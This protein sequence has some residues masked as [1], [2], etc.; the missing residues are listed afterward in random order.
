MN[1]EEKK[2]WLKARKKYLYVEFDCHCV[3]T[4][5]DCIFK[6]RST[7]DCV[8][9]SGCD[10]GIMNEIW[11]EEHGYIKKENQHELSVEKILAEGKIAT[12]I[13]SPDIAEKLKKNFVNCMT[14]VLQEDNNDPINPDHYKAGKLQTIEQMII[15]FGPNK[16]ASFCEV[17]AFKYHARAGLKGDAVLDHK[18]ADWYMRLYDRL[19]VFGC[20]D[21]ENALV[22]L[23]DFLKEEEEKN[24]RNS[25][26]NAS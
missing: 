18:K 20:M 1:I 23:R 9:V 21:S 7:G 22:A 16:V 2:E 6:D 15:V 17:N 13:V 4:C 14:E 12:A 10:R 3:T 26:R 5:D 11:A 24:G 25:D 19:K 8:N